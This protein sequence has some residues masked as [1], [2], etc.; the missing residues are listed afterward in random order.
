[1]VQHLALLRV[2][3]QVKQH[4]IFPIN[5]NGDLCFPNSNSVITKY[6]NGNK[7]KAKI[8]TDFSHE[9]ISNKLIKIPLPQLTLQPKLRL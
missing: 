7:K 3:T 8:K 5:Q 2:D 9:I 6:R 1:M 4:I